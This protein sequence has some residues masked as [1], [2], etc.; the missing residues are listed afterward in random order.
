[1]EK[2]ELISLY[3]HL[4][5]A[6]GNELGE[7]VAYVAGVLKEKIGTRHISNTRYKGV[8]HLYRPQFLI[9]FFE[10]KKLGLPPV[11]AINYLHSVR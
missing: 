9:D 4:G 7:E 11:A 6:A 8:V 1:M 3:D 2:Q 5:Y 10:A